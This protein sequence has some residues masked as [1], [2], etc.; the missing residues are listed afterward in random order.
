MAAP[1]APTAAASVGVATPNR[2]LPSTEAIKMAS[3]K[4]EVASILITCEK[5]ILASSA[6]ILGANLGL[7]MND[8]LNKLLYLS[9]KLV[10]LQNLKA[11]YDYELS[12]DLPQEC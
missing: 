6:E 3:G 2:M 7:R 8:D 12:T 11:C 9:C 1:N 10:V 5:G 4:N